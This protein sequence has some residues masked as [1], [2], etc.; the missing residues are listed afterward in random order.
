MLYPG[1]GLHVGS[2]STL[3]LEVIDIPI[4]DMKVEASNFRL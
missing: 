4:D 3:K 1:L 2:G